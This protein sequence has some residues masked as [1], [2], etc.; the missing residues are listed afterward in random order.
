MSP[1]RSRPVRRRLIRGG[2]V[3]A[4][5]AVLALMIGAYRY[6]VSIQTAD[7]PRSTTPQGNRA[8]AQLLTDDG[9]RVETTDDL[10]SAV[11][12]SDSGTLFVVSSPDV[13]SAE[14]AARIGRATYGRLLLLRPGTPALRAFGLAVRQTASPAGPVAPGCTDPGAV[15][16]G[17]IDLADGRSG[18]RAVGGAAVSLRCYP[19]DAGPTDAGPRDAGVAGGAGWLRVGGPF[20]TVDLV[21]GGIS[22]AVLAHEGNAAFGLNVFG[23]QP[24]IVWLMGRAA[25]A[26]ANGSPGLLP[27]WWIPA[28]AQAFVA[29]VVV[30]IWRGRRLGPILREPLPVTVR[31]AET[32]A[33]HG[34]LYARIGARDRAAQ[35]LRAGVRGR[36]GRRYGHGAY[37]AAGAGTARHDA[38]DVQPLAAAIAA[39]TGRPI[40][41]VG[42]LLA[43]PP[44][45]SD[46]DLV[47]LAAD[48]DRLEQ[49]A[50][51]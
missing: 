40:A 18:Y 27:V 30:G 7:D 32:V 5:V 36:L 44:P 11:A 22:N 29:L 25:A 21:A 12:S 9:V 23:S 16:A 13:L 49:E 4:T 31:A 43:G 10:D 50:H 41:D 47:R 46:D 37:G 2:L 3:L 20:G 6:Q 42:R 45:S 24:R 51:H 26:A 8:L 38:D 33:G 17:A 35:S 1:S 15:A 48:L 34:R 28:I 39:R 14:Q 19:T